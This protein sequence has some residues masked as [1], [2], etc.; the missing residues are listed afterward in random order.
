MRSLPAGYH[1]PTTLQDEAIESDVVVVGSG[2]GG[3]V[4][5]ATFARAGMQVLVVEEGGHYT[6][7]DFRMREEEAYPRLYQDDGGRATE[8]LAITILQG[9]S[10]GGSTTINWTTCFR[11]PENVVD[12]WRTRHGVG[13]FH[14][15]D[16]VPHWQT[17][18]ERL[19]VEPIALQDSNRNNGTLWEGCKALGYDVAVT[20]R[21]VKGCVRSGYCGMGCPIDAKQSMLVTYLPDAVADGAAVLSRC[22]IDRLVPGAGAVT[23]EATLLD[24]DDRRPLRKL[25]IRARRVVL[26]GGAINTPAMLLRSG[27]T[28]GGLVGRRTFLHPTIAQFGLFKTPINGFYGAPQS[29]ASHH[30]AHR[31]DE[32]GFMLETAP[33]HPMLAAMVSPGIGAEHAEMMRKVPFVAGHIALL[34]D[35]FHDDVPGG[36]VKLR[37]GGSPVLSY[38]IPKRLQN[39]AREAA[40]TLARVQLA[41]GATESRTAHDPPAVI[42]SPGMVSM[43]DDWSFGP[44]R[45]GYASAHAMGGCA[46]GDDPNTSV[47]RSDDFRLHALEDVHVI[48]GSLFPTSLGVNP[49]LSI[50]GLARLAATRLV[51]RWTRA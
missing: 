46:M 42:R 4:S 51:S 48:D 7:D 37:P 50:Y 41:A 45:V 22:R 28:A 30:F 14:Y 3:A 40:K 13:G 1:D 29:V 8:D 17:V 9:R 23:L 24:S 47:V 27:I 26:S 20:R 44:N 39:A 10:V 2:A 12:L 43:L 25:T 49:Q 38:P 19:H 33:V 34:I 31:G 15:A 18:E 5:A 36:V 11:T 6:R 35:G 16:L 21:N 32:V